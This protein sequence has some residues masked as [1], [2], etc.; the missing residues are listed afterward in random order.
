MLLARVTIISFVLLC[1]LYSFS[2]AQ[3]REYLRWVRSKPKITKINIDGNKAFSDGAVRKQMYSKTHGFWAALR[4][5]RRIFVQRE[6]LSRDTLEIK[7]LYLK[8]GYLEVKV[9]EEFL[10]DEKD[11]SAT[12]Q[13][14]IEEG[15]QFKFGQKKLTGQYPGKFSYNFDRIADRLKFGKT[16]DV[17]QVRAAIF[18]MKTLMAND[19]FPYGNIEYRIDEPGPTELDDIEFIVVSDSIVHF[20]E[21]TISGNNNFPK[22]TAARELKIKKGNTYRRNDIIESQ[23]RL[24]ESGYFTTVRF[25][26]DDNSNNRYNPDFILNLRE[27][28]PH[29]TTFSTGAGQSIEKDL[30]WNLSGR[31]GKRNFIGSR[32][33]EIL[34]DYSF[35]L[36]N[37]ARLVEHRYRVRYVEPWFL[38]IRMPLI[39]TGEYQPRI[40]IKFPDKQ[41]DRESWATSAETNRRFGTKVRT[42]LGIEYEFV[43][44]SGVSEDSL[45]ILKKDEGNSARRK[46]YGTL[47]SDSRDDLFIPRRGI[48]VDLNPEY[49]GGFLGGD[50]DFVKIQASWSTYQSLKTDLIWATRLRVGWAKAFDNTESVPVDEALFLGGA[51]TIRGFS[52]KSLGPIVNGET[53]GATYTFVFNQEFRWK[54]FQV[55]SYIPVFRE[56]FKSLPLWQS[57]FLDAG[58]GFGDLDD[59]KASAMAYSYGTGIQLISPA[60]PIR[61]DYAQRIPT[62]RISFDSRWHFTILYAF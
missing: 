33:Y 19:G 12:V 17:F 8:S 3:E 15:R 30:V 20:G 39:L 50:A 54:T 37:D 23:T 31:F 13:V 24:L 16:F 57:V 62:S 40:K 35:T 26:Q 14:T 2:H 5:D 43:K 6:T 18:D 9:A 46:I 42:T 11:S 25:S 28:K 22:Y 51:N 52:E 1:I 58:Q 55:L 47:R 44:I 7:Y 56:L 4:R 29:F 49:F 41:F 48:L 32:R 21:L 38:G 36:G 60:G 34:A 61:I 53:I 59:V 45:S 10:L 27:R